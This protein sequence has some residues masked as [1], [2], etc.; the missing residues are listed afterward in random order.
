MRTAALW[1]LRSHYPVRLEVTVIVLAVLALP[2]MTAYAVQRVDLKAM[3]STQQ[4]PIG[5]IV[6]SYPGPPHSTDVV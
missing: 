4:N 3:P 2:F 6:L 1:G 5:S